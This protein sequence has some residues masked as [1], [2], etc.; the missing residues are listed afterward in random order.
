MLLRQVLGDVAFRALL[1]VDLLPLVAQL[2]FQHGV[3]RVGGKH[4]VVLVLLL[5]EARLL[6]HDPLVLH[7][8]LL[9]GW[10]RSSYRTS[11]G[12]S[13]CESHQLSSM[14]VLQARVPLEAPLSASQANSRTQLEME[15]KRCL[16]KTDFNESMY[17]LCL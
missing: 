6:V 11:A 17:I 14:I 7:L 16:T 5:G 8:Q 13:A 1:R 12:T 2:A 15:M 4:L 10:L 9:R 3:L